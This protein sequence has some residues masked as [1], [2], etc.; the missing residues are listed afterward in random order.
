M[1]RKKKK[2]VINKRI[3]TVYDPIFKQEIKVFANCEDKDLIKFYKRCG[4][5]DKIAEEEIVFNNFATHLTKFR[6]SPIYIIFIR[7]FEW[8]LD[9]MNSLIHEIVHTIIAIWDKSNIKVS[10]E[11]EEFFANTIGNLFAEISRKLLNIKVK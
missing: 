2:I 7:H 4:I 5:E 3:F 11:T 1:T 10:D 9:D 6:T 8:T